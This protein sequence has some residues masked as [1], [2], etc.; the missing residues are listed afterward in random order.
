LDHPDDRLPGYRTRSHLI[1]ISLYGAQRRL[2]WGNESVSLLDEHPAGDR[3]LVS[4]S[5]DDFSARAYNQTEVGILTLSD[6]RYDSLMTSFDIGNATFSP[7]GRQL[8]ISGNADKLGIA[9]GEAVA[10]DADI[11]LEPGTDVAAERQRPVGDDG[12][13]AA[14]A[15]RRERRLRKQPHRLAMDG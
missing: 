13:V 7:D 9:R 2:T 14:N 8:L 5:R 1:E 6:G 3:L 4:R 15:G 11:V 10:A 12:L